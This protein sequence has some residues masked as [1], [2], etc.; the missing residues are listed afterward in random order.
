MMWTF[1][2]SRVPLR[3][4][5]VAIG[6]V[7]IS[8]AGVGAQQEGFRVEPLFGITQVYDTNLLFD[9][10][11][12]QPDL[13]TRVSPGIESTYQS[14]L[15]TFSGTYSLDGERF[16][17]HP[18]LSGVNAHRGHLAVGYRPALRTELA[19]DG[20]FMRTLFPGELAVGT[21]LVL[22]P[23]PADQISVRPSIARQL[24]ERTRGTLEYSLSDAQISGFMHVRTQTASVRLERHES[25]RTTTSVA[26]SVDRFDFS[27][28]PTS[29]SQ[30]L[31]VAWK[32]RV[33]RTVTLSLG[34]GPR[35][36]NRHLAPE[37]RAG[38]DADLQ[39]ATFAAGYLRTR[40][41]MVGFLSAVD[42]ESLNVSAAVRP[43][44]HAEL[45]TTPSLYRMFAGGRRA[46]IYRVG[47]EFTQAVTASTAFRAA[48]DT[49]LQDGNIA[50]V[51]F[52]PA[53]FSRH[54]FSISFVRDI[55]GSS[56]DGHADE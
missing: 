24:D 19:V 53:A 46:R 32:R 21:G 38:I 27:S 14:P 44:R 4:S 15:M 6:L 28:S 18:A 20:S 9:A 10:V 25:E 35:V 54:V 55:R 41:A 1:V 33:T 13:I 51:A 22:R 23:A 40:T 45:R 37:L 5:G 50:A 36:D 3:S 47:I 26:Y 48:C 17:E 29:T 34:G 43:W 12:G 56:S 52:G 2:T 42:T 39:H 49:T 8:S 7:M 31:A 30:L 11:S 16:A